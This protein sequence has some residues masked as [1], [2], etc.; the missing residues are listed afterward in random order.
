M[1]RPKEFEREAALEKA[2]RIFWEKGYQATSID[3]L[4]SGMKLGRQSLY[5]TFG[6]KHRL[7][8]EA[9]RRYIDLTKTTVFETLRKG[10]STPLDAIRGD[11]LSVAAGSPEERAWGCMGVNSVN[12]FG[13]GDSDV[14]AIRKASGAYLEG[15]V[16]EMVRAAKRAGDFPATLDEAAATQ[17]L[18]LTRAGLSVSAKSGVEPAQLARMAQF[19]LQRL[20][21]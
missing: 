20:Q 17:F 14:S 16:R 6:D 4:V 15:A 1:A 12:E 7:Y 10:R 2:M 3:D 21:R 18:L 19:A 13:V 11:L 5:D 8:L 9:L